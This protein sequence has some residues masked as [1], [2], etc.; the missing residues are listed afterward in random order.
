MGMK[1]AASPAVDPSPPHMAR[2]EIRIFG[3]LAVGK[4]S[5]RAGCCSCDDETKNTV[6][7]LTDGKI[8]ARLGAARVP[9]RASAVKFERR[10]GAVWLH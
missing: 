9:L 8:S 4:Y 5:V 7:A 2:V 6:E 1:D 10:R 3:M